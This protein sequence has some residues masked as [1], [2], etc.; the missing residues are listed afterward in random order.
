MSEASLFGK[1]V[2]QRLKFIAEHREKLMEAW[3]AETGFLPS[4]SMLMQREKTGVIEIWVEKKYPGLPKDKYPE[5][6]ALREVARAA[7]AWAKECRDDL[8]HDKLNLTWL[9]QAL[10]K[11][12]K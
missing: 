1:L 3:V 9:V 10:E 11:L 5:M 2:D 6:D 7:E 4:E 12:Q 8:G